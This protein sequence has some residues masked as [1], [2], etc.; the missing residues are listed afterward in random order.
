ML[1]HG[2]RT[3]TCPLKPLRLEAGEIMQNI[4]SDLGFAT[5]EATIKQARLRAEEACD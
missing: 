1:A 4:L 3:I 5:M 2:G